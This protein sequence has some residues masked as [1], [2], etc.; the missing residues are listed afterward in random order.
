VN[1][2]S[3]SET[4]LNLEEQIREDG[5][6]KTPPIFSRIMHNKFLN[7]SEQI[8]TN[9]MEHFSYDFLFTDAGFPVRYKVPC[10]GLLYPIMLFPIILGI[11]FSFQYYKREGIFLLGWLL[12]TPIGSA[13]TFDDI[14][15]LQRSLLMVIPLC[16]FSS[17]GLVQLW[18]LLKKRKILR[19]IIYILFGIF[20]FYGFIFYI[21]NY[22]VHGILHRPWY[23]QEG[24][25]TMVSVVDKLLP[26]YKK[27]VITNI[28]SAPAIFVLF[29]NH[30]NPAL[31]QQQTKNSKM[32]D[33]DRINFSN[34]E[35]YQEECPLQ[36]RVDKFGKKY[37]I[38]KE[39]VLYVNGGNCKE[40]PGTKQLAIIHRSDN[41]RVFR[42][43]TI[44]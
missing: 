4:Q 7:Y 17:Y 9:Y 37:L 2:F 25:K 28:E 13:L 1:V 26:N 31:F 24:Y 44:K 40:I 8:W 5:V 34:Y 36:L 42:I 16:I 39:N 32:K 22:Y 6:K 15:N 29:Y 41:S 18:L 43:L 11:W 14:P 3:V 20:I 30:Y 19:G 12:M 38:G 35:F 33:F 27:A 10:M 21:H 23:R